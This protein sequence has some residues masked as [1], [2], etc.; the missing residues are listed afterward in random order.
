MP[1]IERETVDTLTAISGAEVVPEGSALEALVAFYRGFNARD[2]SA[3][4]RNWLP[5]ALPSMDNPIGGIRR[6]IE[7]ICAGYERL[8]SGKARVRVEFFDFTE[9]HGEEFHLFVGRERGQCVVDGEIVDQA[10][11]FGAPLEG[12]L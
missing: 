4:E 6:G 10:A 12:P 9:S 3:L 5:G 1:H 11:I 8:F 7:A 2:L